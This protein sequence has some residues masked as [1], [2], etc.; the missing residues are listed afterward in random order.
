MFVGHLAVGF[1]GKKFAPN[2]SLG[3]LLLAS[4]VADIIWPV[5]VL[6][7][8]EHVRIVP[9]ITAASPLDLYDF[10]ISHSLLLDVVWAGVFAGLYYGVRRYVR[11]AWVLFAAVISHWVLDWLSHRPDMPLAPG[12]TGRFGAGV[13][14]SVPLTLLVEGGLWVIGVGIY[15]RATRAND[16]IGSIAFWP[17]VVVLTGIWLASVFGPPPPDARTAA[18][19]AL[20]MMVI[21][22]W[23]WWIDN[24]R[25][26]GQVLPGITR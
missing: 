13:W 21:F 20:A 14:N 26:V 17:M 1:A 2:T 10:P 11:G 7:G 6:A 16:R 23:G 22:A 24:H 8:I 3:S 25:P 18:I 9:G 4:Q 15:V 19:S 5:L 12:L